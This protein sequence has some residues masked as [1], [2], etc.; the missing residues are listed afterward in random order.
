[1]C[2]TTPVLI[3]LWFA[4]SIAAVTTSKI[5]VSS[6]GPLQLC[7]VQFL[8]AALIERI[9]LAWV[10]HCIRPLAR[11]AQLVKRVA[12]TYT[13]GFAFTNIAFSL[14]N[15][16]LVET[17]KAGEPIST[18]LL[19]AMML[20][21]VERV[22]TYISLVPIVLGVALASSGDATFNLP[23][24]ASTFA[25]NIC[26]SSRTVLTKKMKNAHPGCPCATSE[27]CLFYHV[28]KLG[29]LLLLLPALSLQSMA[30][31]L[32]DGQL[33]NQAA[34]ATPANAMPLVMFLCFNAT[35]YT[36]YNQMS[37]MVLS[38]VSSATHAVLNM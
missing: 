16:S 5:T 18:V 38:R 20:G 31:L 9:Q 23:S 12:L 29:L 37:W 21:E 8:A 27:T 4:A 3:I 17:V 2:L 28:S 15:A 11:E 1:M 26:F 25:A 24:S 34:A 30:W 10:Q 36:M 35:M 33:A 22:P 32:V 19:A 13:L 14:A 6:V 7:T